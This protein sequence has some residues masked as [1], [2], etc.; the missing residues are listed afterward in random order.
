MI[1]AF[2][3]LT[4]AIHRHLGDS[5]GLLRG[6]APAHRMVVDRDVQ[7]VDREGN[8][9]VA[10][11]TVWINNADTPVPGDAVTLDGLAY[12]L[13]TRVDDDGYSTRFVAVRTS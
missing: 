1:P 4:K 2:Q 11:V 7:L 3:R 12:K 13:D 6:A 5:D 8:V 9:Y 10:E